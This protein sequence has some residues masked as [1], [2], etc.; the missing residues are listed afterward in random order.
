MAFRPS[1]PLCI[2]QILLSPLFHSSF[3]RF[4]PVPLLPTAPPFCFFLLL[5]SFFISFV[6]TSLPSAV[7]IIR[8]FGSGSCQA[9]TCGLSDRW[10]PPTSD[11]SLSPI[12]VNVIRSHHH[13]GDSKVFLSSSDSLTLSRSRSISK[14]GSSMLQVEASELNKLPETHVKK[15]NSM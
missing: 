8:R 1:V 10:F 15:A 13:Q 12:L 3:F 11:E 6:S 4:C 5:S 9:S 2:C 7:D 14:G